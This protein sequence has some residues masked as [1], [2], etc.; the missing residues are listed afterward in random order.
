M[1][2][3]PLPRDETLLL[4]YELLELPTA[5]HKAGLAGLLLHLDSLA[6]RGI[7]GAPT[8]EHL[9]QFAASIRV[10]RNSLQVLFDDLYAARLERVLVRSKYANKTPL[11]ETTVE[12][13]R[14]GKLHQ[15]KRF[16]YEEV[17]PSGPVLTH[18]LREGDEDPWFKL[19][20]NMLWSVLRAQPATRREY[21][22]RANEQPVGFGDKFW[23]A[24]TKAAKQRTKGKFV[25]E[26][27]AGSL[28]VGAQDK[29][30]ERVIFVGR[31]EHNLL[32]HFWQW[33]TPIFVPR[34]LDPRKGNW[35]YQGFLL[36]IPE[37]ADLIEFPR[38]MKHY[39]QDLDPSRSGYRPA[40]SLV[41]LAEEGGLEF[42]YHLVR[43]RLNKAD[44][45]Y[46]VHAIELYHQEKRG[47]SVRQITAERLTPSKTLLGAYERIR[48]DRRKH[49]LFKRLQIGNLVHGES[50]FHGALDLFARFPAEFFIHGPNT[51]RGRFFGADVRHRFKQAIRDLELKEQT[52]RT[53]SDDEALQRLIY[54]LIRSYVD[55]RT[56]NRAALPDKK[57]D[58]LTTAE[59]KKYNDLKPKVAI[60]A[61]LALRGRR[62]QDITEY[63]T[64]TLC[65]TGHYLKEEEFLLLGNALM[66]DPDKVKNL[67]ML[68]LSAHSWTAR[69]KKDIPDT[70]ETQA[71]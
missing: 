54:Q 61:F 10:D 28:F 4:E 32:L 3:E 7:P 6:E 24:F 53:S 70:T 34:V 71:N 9:G 16:V 14:D 46:G 65:S 22:A 36:A 19:W 59:K 31:V 67:A 29:N 39:W 11:E 38:D 35:N 42:L 1:N 58:A 25:T 23:A 47:N 17:R 55:L 21:Q 37:V 45:N 18:W 41:D 48:D 26:S 68:A 57:Y 64:G 20:Q 60:T 13:R 27:I 50:W 49:P 12:V 52:M 30:A 43:Q 63:F 51:P 56:K 62:E 66:R 40:E 2:A 69:E 5:Q 33:A 15:E 8:V 44:L